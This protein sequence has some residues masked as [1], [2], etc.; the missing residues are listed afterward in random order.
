VTSAKFITL[1]EIYE[2]LDRPNGGVEVELFIAGVELWFAVALM[3]TAQTMWNMTTLREFYWI[4]P[5]YIIALPWLASSAIT[6]CGLLLYRWGNR[7]AS[8]VRLIGAH[9][10]FII[11]S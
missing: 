11:G 1:S 5:H 3:S 8:P 10:S 4:V 2:F 6:I 9:I 7:W